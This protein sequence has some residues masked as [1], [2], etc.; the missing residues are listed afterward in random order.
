MIVTLP[1][2]DKIITIFLQHLC[3]VSNGPL[4]FRTWVSKYLCY[5][6]TKSTYNVPRYFYWFVLFLTMYCFQMF[7][8]GEIK[9]K[10]HSAYEGSE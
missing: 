10:L 9:G 3:G 7:L 5:T 4:L 1:Y 2:N 6:D 8:W